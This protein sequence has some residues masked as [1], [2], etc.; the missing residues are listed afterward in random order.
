MIRNVAIIGSGPAGYTAG[1][2]NAR[3]DL[4]PIIIEGNQPGGQLTITT[5]VD[6]FPGFPEGIMGPV[7]MDE[8]K[9]QALRFGAE[10][11][12][13]QIVSVDFS[14]RPFRL[15]LDNH[16]TIQANAVIIATGAS[17]RLLG[18]P[19]ETRLMGRG[20]SACA[21]CDGFF[22]RD[23]EVVV[24]GGGDTAIE[25]ANFLTRFATRV[26]VI[27]RRDQLRASKIMQDRAFANQKITF[28]W[29]SVVEEILGETEG[30][31]TG[32]RLKNIRS[33]EQTE[34]P[35]DGVFIAIGHQPNTRIFRE[36][37]ELDDKGY[38]ILKR[39]SCTSVPGVFA[40]GDVVDPIYKQA[41]IA[42]G[43]GCMAALDAEQFL[44]DQ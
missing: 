20:V 30:H 40:A 22:F 4:N 27:H 3:A 35:C 6:N 28:I 43:M 11:M 31:V 29:D 5:E 1:I 24:I 34:M 44:L 8:M 38:N 10:I 13:G 25:E 23:K 9:K 21:T 42:A 33:G 2:Y 39:K 18:I 19:S 7:L 16:E 32:V 12:T 37:I 26:S 41:V 17:A 15:Q 14:N 36:Q